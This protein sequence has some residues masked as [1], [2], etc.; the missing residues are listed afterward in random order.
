MAQSYN[1]GRRRN[2]SQSRQTGLPRFLT[3]LGDFFDRNMS[4]LL[5]VAV[6]AVCI[7]ILCGIVGFAMMILPDATGV[8]KI[9]VPDMVGKTYHAGELDGDIFRVIIEYE[10]DSQLPVGVVKEQYPPANLERK[11]VKGEHLCTLTLTL[12]RGKNTVMLPSLSGLGAG[13]AEAKLTALGL[14]C[15]M[16]Y[17]PDSTAGAGTVLS[18]DPAAYADVPV[19][20]TVQI[21]VSGEAGGTVVMPS[22]VG[23]SETEAR[24]RLA[25]LGLEV[26]QSEYI[27]SD[28]P[29]G[30]VVEQSSPFGA[31]MPAGATV[32]L[33][34]STG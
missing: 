33:T 34:V 29:A 9:I 27:P 8:Q 13:E 25:A 23:L 12:S 19:G 14:E 24:E 28:R 16:V 10:Y 6:A 11:V 21:K 30:T 32:Y 26:G 3:R 17:V 15:E 7:T 31:Q 20:A 4:T 1:E 2:Y 18:T 5:G 22:L